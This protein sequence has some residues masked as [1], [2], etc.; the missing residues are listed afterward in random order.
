M[1]HVAPPLPPHQRQGNEV[2]TAVR[3]RGKDGGGGLGSGGG[4]KALLLRDEDEAEL[5]EAGKVKGV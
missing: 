2:W 5:K 1:K 3:E 4:E